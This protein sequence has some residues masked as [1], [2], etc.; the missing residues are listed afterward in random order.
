MVSMHLYKQHCHAKEMNDLKIFLPKVHD[1]LFLDCKGYISHKSVNTCQTFGSC[2][3]TQM[4]IFFCQK[5][6]QSV[7]NG[8]QFRIKLPL[9]Q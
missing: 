6:S 5:K 8:A 7:S 1:V 2:R 9:A 3:M 4:S